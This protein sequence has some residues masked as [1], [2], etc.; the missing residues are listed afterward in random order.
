[1]ADDREDFLRSRQTNALEMAEDPEVRRLDLDLIAASDR[2]DWSY[3]WLWLGVPVIQMPTDLVVI[4]ELIWANRPEII[5]ETGVARG[6]SAIFHASMLQL[7]GAGEVVAVDID[8]RAHNRASIEEHPLASRVTLLEGG[9]TDEDVLATVR[10]KCDGKRTMV[11][12]DSDHTHQHVLEELRVYSPLVTPGQFLI[13]ADTMI[14]EIPPQEH[15]PRHWGPGNNPMSAVRTFLQE[16]DDFEVDEHAN[17]KLLLTSS[18]GG[19]L[20]RR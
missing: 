11:V 2:H 3:Q 5:V 16:S 15:R 7:L 4:Q 8:I 18:R 9:S 19:Y 14:E 20:R 6:G 13:V 1:M 12:L 17:A 10:A